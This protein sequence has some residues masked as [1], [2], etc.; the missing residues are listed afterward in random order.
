[1]GI[2]RRAVVGAHVLIV[3]AGSIGLF[4]GCGGPED[5]AQVQEGRDIAERRKTGI[6]DAM[7]SGA[8]GRLG[9]KGMEKKK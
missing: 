5:G 7:K 2:L 9:Q 6:R 1:M 3:G 4:A 8:Y